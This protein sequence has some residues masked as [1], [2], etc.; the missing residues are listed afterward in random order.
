MMRNGKNGI[1][2]AFIQRNGTSSLDS[3]A[4]LLCLFRPV[5]SFIFTLHYAPH[6]LAWDLSRH[7]A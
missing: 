5:G 3:L 7:L 6:A 2:I 1:M 4:E